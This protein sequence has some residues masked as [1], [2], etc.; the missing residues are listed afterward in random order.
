MSRPVWHDLALAAA[1][2]ARRR[3]GLDELLVVAP[4]PTF[5]PHA[6]F[7]GGAVRDD[8]D[9]G[10]DPATELSGAFG[11]A[12]LARMCVAYVGCFSSTGD[13][14]G[15]AREVGS[16][17][18]VVGQVIVLEV[19]IE[20]GS[21]LIEIPPGADDL[22]AARIDCREHRYPAAFW[23]DPVIRIT[24]CGPPRR[25]VPGVSA[26]DVA[27]C[28]HQ[29][30]AA[31][32]TEAVATAGHRLTIPPD[33]ADAVLI[34]HD[35]PF[36]GRLRFVD[37]CVNDGGR[38]FLYP[39]GADPA[40][41]SGWDG[42]YPVYPRLAGAL[43]IGGGY[44]EVARAFGYPLPVHVVGWPYCELAPRRCGPVNNVLFAPTHPP[45]LDNPRYPKRNVEVFERLLACPVRLTV[46]YLGALEANGLYEVPGVTYIRG[47]IFD[48]PGMIE[49]IDA[50]DCVVADRATF[51]NL[52]IARGVT[53]VLWDSAIVFDNSGTRA[54]DHL[55]LYRE[56][57]RY[58]FDVDNGDLWGTITAA[59]QDSEQV[60]RWRARFIGD[61]LDPEAVIDALTGR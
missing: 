33:R 24:V 61:P 56:L 11:P 40:L 9:E 27:V 51:G 47:D 8:A 7:A 16:L 50:V 6:A 12:R 18:G 44:A 32:F 23:G 49:Q 13:K 3:A 28:D 14:A 1:D 52:A 17:V 26:L 25:E 38:G 5:S 19:E 22:R 20:T 42:L 39:H 10:S 54:P 4:F 37:A 48:S 29:G 57:L 15:L 34:D 60:A 41:M 45:Y 58:P 46:R 59:S 55:D 2:G 43:V 30:K 21:E 36:H 31:P 35:V 53:T